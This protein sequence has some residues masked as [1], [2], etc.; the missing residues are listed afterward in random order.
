MENFQY[1]VQLSD[2]DWA[3]FSAA[4][5][6]CGLLQAGLASGEKPDFNILRQGPQFRGELK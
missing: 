6:E 1:S 2:Q 5:E 3:E 4:A